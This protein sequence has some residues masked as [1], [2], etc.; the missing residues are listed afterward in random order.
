MD[1]VAAR[2]SHD[3]DHLAA[4]LRRFL[5]RVPEL[6][7]IEGLSAHGWRAM[8]VCDRRLDG[9]DH[10]EIAAQL[11]MSLQMVMRYSRHIDQEELAWRGNAKHER[12]ANKIEKRDR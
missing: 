4:S 3:G 9:L 2:Q 7:K 5:G 10:Q 1:R 11:C 8:A 12:A 6:A